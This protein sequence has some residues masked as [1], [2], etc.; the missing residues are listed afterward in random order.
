L[1]IGNQT[2]GG[3]GAG[4]GKHG[5]AVPGFGGAPG[6]FSGT[7]QPGTNGTAGTAG[8]GV[9]GGVA[10]LAP[11]TT[12]NTTITGNHDSTSNGDVSGTFSM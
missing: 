12:D 1:I 4:G 8:S 2:I 11:A 10:I 3:P 9:G 5:T 7:S 6:E